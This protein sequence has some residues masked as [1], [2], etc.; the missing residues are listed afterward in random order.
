M[1]RHFFDL[2]KLYTYPPSRSCRYVSP[3][4]PSQHLNLGNATTL[5]LVDC[6]VT[7]DAVALSFVALRASSGQTYVLINVLLA[8]GVP[9]ITSMKYAC[10]YYVIVQYIYDSRNGD[11]CGCI[12][13]AL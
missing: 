10:A 9:L 3:L 11:D 6:T 12:F 7:F 4:P 8:K 5:Q 1:S 2:Y 13:S